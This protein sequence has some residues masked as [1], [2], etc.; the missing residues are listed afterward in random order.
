MKNISF[1]KFNELTKQN[2]EHKINSLD[3]RIRNEYLM[4]LYKCIISIQNNLTENQLQTLINEKLQFGLK[5]FN[6]EQFAQAYCELSVF[7]HF[8]NAKFIKDVQYE[9]RNS[10]NKK[11]VDLSVFIENRIFNIEVKCSIPENYNKKKNGISIKATNRAPDKE[12]FQ[13]AVN[14]IRK[15]IPED[16]NLHVEKNK[17]NTLKDFIK[18]TQ[19]KCNNFNS[20]QDV[21]ILFICCDD[22]LDIMQWR[23][24]LVYGFL[25]L[26]P[27]IMQH[28]DFLS[29]DCIVFSN[30]FL[31]YRNSYNKIHQ[32][33]LDDIF[34]LVYGNP[35]SQRYTQKKYNQKSREN[36]FK[37]DKKILSKYL[38]EFSQKFEQFMLTGKIPKYESKET[39][40]LLGLAWFSDTLKQKFFE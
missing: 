6:E 8:V 1:E 3:E 40:R 13:E 14:E 29:V 36:V 21:N 17:D 10:G 39:K 27:E 9:R 35:Y 28:E 38:N 33:G 22:Q 25:D 26:N 30:L 7:S 37:K 16:I 5:K 32:I 24:Y 15:R 19:D 23:E 2:S 20:V 12:L 31:K 18:S 34:C 11:D 4:E